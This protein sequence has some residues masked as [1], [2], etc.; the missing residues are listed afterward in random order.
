MLGPADIERLARAYENAPDSTNDPR[1]QQMIAAERARIDQ[2]FAVLPL[3]VEFVDHDPYRSFEHM[4]DQIMTTGTMYVFKGGSD[5]PLWDPHTNW[6]A[7]AVHDF[8]HLQKSCDFSI[9][10]EAV[11]YRSSAAKCHALAPLYMSEILL[12]AAVAN[13]RGSF[14]QQKLV[15][16]PENVVRWASHLRGLRGLGSAAAPSDHAALVWTTAGIL[17]VD[18]PE[19]AI[20]HLRAMGIDFEPAAVIIDAAATLNADIDGHN[21]HTPLSR[22]YSKAEI[23]AFMPPSSAEQVQQWIQST[24]RLIVFGAQRIRDVDPKYRIRVAAAVAALKR[25]DA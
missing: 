24:A 14:A 7:R 19:A 3:N 25:D 8:D 4:R 5:T 18:S 1:V 15:L 17:R 9:E 21:Y 6:K 16:L 10:G 23:D 22:Q 13:A 20:M 11:A 12:Q 2:A